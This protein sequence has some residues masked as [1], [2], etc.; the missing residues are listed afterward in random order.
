MMT[1]TTYKT[2]RQT[3]SK[4]KEQQTQL[5]QKMGKSGSETEFD[6]ICTKKYL[7]KLLTF[8]CIYSIY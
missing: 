1:R 4:H 3:I 2:T 5:S 6:F 8:D 7:K